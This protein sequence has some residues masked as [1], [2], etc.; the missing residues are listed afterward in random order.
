MTIKR[1]SNINAFWYQSKDVDLLNGG[2]YLYNIYN[3]LPGKAVL[4]HHTNISENLKWYRNQQSSAATN[5]PQTSKQVYR[6]ISN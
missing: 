1:Y 2:K 6:P 5:S 4:V 3:N